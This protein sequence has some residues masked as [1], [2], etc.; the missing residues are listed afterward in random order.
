MAIQP[1]DIE[2]MVEKGETLYQAIAITAKRAR[3][4]NQDIMQE[5]E[6][7]KST[8][9]PMEEDDDEFE[10]T[11]FDQMRISLEL[12]KRGKPTAEALREFMTDELTFRMRDKPQN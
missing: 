5:F 6:S 9:V 1:T 12:E 4:I 2:L 8:L 11:N 7:R 10:T 3:Q